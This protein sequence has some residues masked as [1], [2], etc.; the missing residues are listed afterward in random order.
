MEQKAE[1]T[2]ASS[3]PAVSPATGMEGQ[4]Q[5]GGS[6]ESCDTLLLLF[7][8]RHKQGVSSKYGEPPFFSREHQPDFEC[9]EYEHVLA[10]IS[11]Y[12]K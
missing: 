4:K 5:G 3:H 10:V 1:W 12:N 8:A 6:R 11:M 2:G 9:H 7:G